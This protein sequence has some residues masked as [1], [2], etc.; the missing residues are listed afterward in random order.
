[1]GV[2][3]LGMK[4]PG[5]NGS[6]LIGEFVAPHVSPHESGG[7]KGGNCPCSLSGLFADGVAVFFEGSFDGSNF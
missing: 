4:Y 1:M 6:G 7:T 3:A 5:A 2:I